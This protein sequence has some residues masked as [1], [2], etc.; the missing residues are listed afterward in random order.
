MAE[1]YQTIL[2]TVFIGVFIFACAGLYFSSCNSNV[3]LG[4]SV[5]TEAP[6][7]SIDYPPSNAVVR[8]AFVLAGECSDDRG[9]DKVEITIAN[10]SIVHTAKIE[11]DGTWKVDINNKGSD[12]SYP[13]ADGK[14]VFRAV[15]YDEV[16]RKSAIAERAIEIDN[17]EPVFIIKSPGG[18]DIKNPTS[19][20]SMFKV[21]GNIADDHDIKKF[22]VTIYDEA[23][24]KLRELY[25]ENISVAG[26]T[27]ITF[28]QYDR[29]VQYT[30]GGE[31]L[32]DRYCD[33]YGDNTSGDKPFYC[34]VR[35]VDAAEKYTTPKNGTGG[36]WNTSPDSGSEGN[37]TTK[38]YLYD[39]VY[40]KYMG[41]NSDYKLTANDF[42]AILNGSYKVADTDEASQDG[43]RAAGITSEDATKLRD[44][45]K[46]ILK[47][48]ATEKQRLTFKLN[49]DANPHY[50]FSGY[51]LDKSDN[52]YSF[53]NNSASK[54]SKITFTAKMGL[55]E[56]Y[57]DPKTI[58]VYCFGPYEGEVNADEMQT[59]YKDPKAYY[60]AK[61]EK[62]DTNKEHILFDGSEEYS[63]STTNSFTQTF[64]MGDISDGK[65]YVLAAC[66]KD[67]DDLEL[68]ESVEYGFEGVASGQPPRITITK[69]TSSNNAVI[70][71]DGDM[72]ITGT[73]TSA[74]SEITG[75]RYE[76]AVY[77]EGNGNNNL[78]TITGNV[79]FTKD[80]E[81]YNW[82]FDIKAAID[83]N[84]DYSKYKAKDGNN[85]KYMITVVAKN[86]LGLEGQADTTLAVD[87]KKP[88]INNITVTP[89]AK[90][91]TN[92]V[93]NGRIKVS[94][95]ISDS[96]LAGTKTRLILKQG[97]TVKK[98]FKD[99]YTDSRTLIEEYIYTTEFDDNKDLTFEVTVEDKAGNSAAKTTVCYIDQSTDYPKVS[100]TGAE[101]S[102]SVKNAGDIK[103]GKNLFGVSSR[104]L[105]G[106]VS[107]DDGIG[108]AYIS[109]YKGE[110][111]KEEMASKTPD[112]VNKKSIQSTLSY[113]LPEK[114]G[115]YTVVV[116]AADKRD[117]DD[118]TPQRSITK[119]YYVAVDSGAPTI[120]EVTPASG[121]YVSEKGMNVKGTVQDGSEIKNI[122]VITGIKQN[123]GTIKWDETNGTAGG[124]S[125]KFNKD[126]AKTATNYGKKYTIEDKITPPEDAQGT[127][128]VKYIATD[129]YGQSTEYQITYNID[130]GAPTFEITKVDN[131]SVLL[132]GGEATAPAPIFLNKSSGFLDVA[133]NVKDD[134]AFDGFVYYKLDTTVPN[135]N[136][137]KLSTDWGRS[138]ISTTD[139]KS[140]TWKLSIPV[141]SCTLVTEYFLYIT[142]KDN[143][144]NVSMPTANPSGKVSVIPDGDVPTIGNFNSSTKSISS[145]NSSS[146][147][148]FTVT[149]L[150]DGENGSGI[151]RVLLLEDGNQAVDAEFKLSDDKTEGTLTVNNS[152]YK[153]LY[154]E[155]R[156]HKIYAGVYDKV[157]NYAE[158][159]TVEI[160]VDSTAPMVN[161]TSILQPVVKN[162]VQYFNGVVTAN[163]IL[164][165]ETALSKN[166]CYWYV[167]Y[168]SGDKISEVGSDNI[169]S[170]IIAPNVKENKIEINDNEIHYKGIVLEIDTTKISGANDTS[171]G[172]YTL[173]V[174]AVDKGGNKAFAQKELKIDQSTDLP[175]L[176][177]N[178]VDDKV[179]AETI[180]S[181]KNLF[182]PGKT[183]NVSASDDDG[184]GAITYILYKGKDTTGTISQNNV[185]VSNSQISLPSEEGY[186]TLVVTVTDKNNNDP[187][188]P[189]ATTKTYHIAVDSGAPTFESVEPVSGKYYST[190]N[191]MTVK[192]TVKDENGIE[193]NESGIAQI[194]RENKK[195]GTAISTVFVPVDDNK[196]FTDTVTLASGDGDYEVVYTATD[197]FGQ[198]STH[199]I[200]YKVDSVAPEFIIKKINGKDVTLNVSSSIHPDTVYLNK[201]D[202]GLEVSGTVTDA[203]AGASGFDGFVYYALA[204]SAPNY[205]DLSDSS[206]WK[207]TGFETS[208]NKNGKWELS[209][210]VKA[211]NYVSGTDYFLYIAFKDDAGNISKA[212]ANDTKPNGMVKVIPD[213]KA[214]TITDL[215]IITD[216]LPDGLT[217]ENKDKNVVVTATVKDTE[218]G[219]ASVDLYCNGENT[220]LAPTKTNDEYKFTITPAYSKLYASGVHTL[221]VRATDKTR[222]E[223][224]ASDTISVDTESPVIAINSV[225]PRVSKD[226]KEY[227]NGVVTVSASLQDETEL[228]ADGCYWYVTKKGD[229]NKVTG[230]TNAESDGRIIIPIT[231]SSE[232]RY[233]NLSISLN[234]T[235]ISGEN[236]TDTTGKGEYTLH[237]YAV[238]KAGN[239][240]EVTAELNIDQSTDLPTLNINDVDDS[241]SADNITVDAGKNLFNKGK[242]LNGSASDDDGVKGITYSLYTGKEVTG[243]PATKTANSSTISY[244][245]PD[246]EGYYTL[247]VTVSDTN[248]GTGNPIPTRTITKTYHIAVDSGAPT[249]TGVTP[250]NGN[251]FSQANK[252]TV[253]GTVKDGNEIKNISV[254]TGKEVEKDG[255]IKVEWD[256][257][258]GTLGGTSETFNKTGAINTNTT[259][260]KTYTIADIITPPADDGNYVVKY[261]ATDVFG[262]SSEHEIKYMVDSAAPTFTIKKIGSDSVNLKGGSETHATKVFL[263]ESNGSL[264]VSGEVEDKVSGFDGFAYYALSASETAPDY[265]K[266]SDSNVWKKSAIATSDNKSGKWELSIPVK[267]YT[268][269]TSYYLHMTFKDGAGN[270][271]KPDENAKYIV[272]VIPDKDAPTIGALYDNNQYANPS[273]ITSANIHD[274]VYDDVVI[275]ATVMDVVSGVASVALYCDGEDTNL[276][277]TNSTGNE[278][279]LTIKKTG[280]N[281]YSKL[282]DSGVHNLELRATDK[283]GNIAS[284]T[285]TLSVDTTLP[286]VSINSISPRVSK[287]SDEYLNGTV[288]VSA[289]LTD[290]TA[291]VEEGDDKICYWYVTKENDTAKIPGITA[292]ADTEGKIKIPI[293]TSEKQYKNL[294]IL[295]DTTKI[296]GENATDT[297]GKGKYILHIYA[298]DKAGND[299]TETAELNID[300]STDIPEISL[301]KAN[302]DK[303]GIEGNT[304]QI[305]VKDDD[306]IGSVT[307]KLDEATTA[308][309]IYTRTDATK[310]TDY[311]YTITLPN[312]IST[313]EHTLTVEVEDF[314]EETGR[315]AK[316]NEKKLKFIYDND[317]PVI[318]IDSLLEFQQETLTIKVSASDKAGI[319]F[320]VGTLEKIKGSVTETVFGKD[321]PVTANFS[322]TD[323][324]WMATATIPNDAI[325]DSATYKWT[326]TVT[327]KYGRTSTAPVTHKVDV[328]LPVLVDS[329]TVDADKITF[330]A[331]T[332]TVY[333]N[334]ITADNNSI[335]FK[336]GQ[337]SI[338]ISGKLTETN[339]DH[340]IMTIEGKDASGNV[341]SESVEYATATP[342][343]SI[344][345]TYYDGTNQ[346]VLKA[347][348]KAGN[349]S[350]T[351][352]EFTLRVDTNA[353]SLLG[354]KTITDAN[355]K[356]ITSGGTVNTNQLK[357]SYKATDLVENSTS[358][359][360]SGLAQIL[361]GS[362]YGFAE[363][364]ALYNSKN[365]DGTSAFT[366]GTQTVEKTDQV[367]SLTS[368]SEG[369]N[370]LYIRLID[371]AGNVY[372]DELVKFTYD[373]TPATVSIASPAAGATVN[374]TITITGSVSD[375]IGLPDAPTGYLQIKIGSNDWTN[376]DA[377]SVSSEIFSGSSWSCKFDTTK[378]NATG[379]D[380]TVSVRMII[381]DKA[382]NENT[383]DEGRQIII[384]QDSDRPQIVLTNMDI[385]GTKIKQSTMVYG[386]LTDD[387]SDSTGVVQG[388][389][390]IEKSKFTAGKYPTTTADNGWTKLAV[391]AGSGSFSYEGNNEGLLEFYFYCIDNE[392]TSFYW[393]AADALG[394]MKIAGINNKVDGE[395]KYEDEKSGISYTADMNAPVVSLEVAR[396]DAPTD[397]SAGSKVFSKNGNYSDLYM[398]LTVVEAVEMKKDN[399]G[400]FATPIVKLN[401]N[402]I[403]DTL[404]RSKITIVDRIDD[405]RVNDIRK[406]IDVLPEAYKPTDG[407]T[408]IYEIGPINLSNVTYDKDTWSLS[409]EVSDASDQKGVGNMNITMDQTAPQILITSPSPSISDAVMAAITI[410]GLA[411]DDASSIKDLRWAIP[412]TASATDS[413]NKYNTDDDNLGLFTP[414]GASS[415]WEIKFSSGSQ[416][417]PDSLLFYATNST[418][419]KVEQTVSG[420]GI[421]KVPIWFYV[422]DAVG[423]K[424][425]QTTD[426]D[427]KPLE[428]YVDADGGK[429]K[430]W[431]NSPEQN[432]TVTGLVTIY[433]G[434]SD[435]ISVDKVQ[436]QVDVNGDGKYDVNDYTSIKD[437]GTLGTDIQHTVE[438]SADG[439]DWWIPTIG[440]N[441]WKVT[442]DTS[443]V[444]ST[445]KIKI[446]CRAYDSETPKPLTRGWN[447]GEALEVT[448]DSNAPAIRDVKLVQ[449]G[450]SVDPMDTPNASPVSELE[451]TSGMYISNVS[452]ATN[453]TWYLTAKVTDNEEV[454]KI[455]TASINV[456][457]STHI[458]DL[459][460]DVL[461]NCSTGDGKNKT[462]FIPITTTQSG[463]VYSRLTVKDNVDG[464]ALKE[465][466]INIDSTA[467]SLFG[468]DS[469]LTSNAANKLRLKP[470]NSNNPIGDRNVPNREQV[471]NSNGLFTFGDYVQEAESGLAFL[472]FYFE[473]S[474]TI[475]D[476]MNKG[477]T[478]TTTVQKN[479]ENLPALSLTV[480]R[481]SEDSLTISGVSD[482]DKTFIRKGGLVK[483]GGSYRLITKVDGNTI[484]FTP[485]CS[486]SFTTAEI[487]FAQIVD[488]QISESVKDGKVDPNYDD[489]DGMIESVNHIGSSYIWSASIDS[490][491]IADGPITIGVAA[492]DNAGNIATGSIATF[493]SNNRPR[494]AK[495]MLATDLNGDD[496]FTYAA[497]SNNY[498]PSHDVSGL[499]ET[500]RNSRL[501]YIKN[502]LLDGSSFGEFNYYKVMTD[503][504]IAQ[505]E[506]ELKS[507]AFKVVTKLCVLPEFVGGN[508]EI[509][510]IMTQSASKDDKYNSK[511]DGAESDLKSMKAKTA[512][513]EVA[514]HANNPTGDQ[515]NSII[516]EK[517][518]I[519]I[520]TLD[521]NLVNADDKTYLSFTFW[522]KTEGTNQGETSQWAH[523]QV[524]ITYLTNETNK[525]TPTINPFYWNSKTDNS[526]HKENGKLLGH[527]E[528]GAQPQVSGKIVIEGIAKDDVRLDS[529]T[530]N[531]SGIVSGA[532]LSYS[533]GNWTSSNIPTGM[534]FSGEDE[535]ISQNG[536][537][538]K[539]TLVCDTEVLSTKAGGSHITVDATDWRNNTHTSTT[540]MPSTTDT[541][542]T[543]HYEINVVPYITGVWTKLSE[544]YRSAPSVYARTALGH[545]PVSAGETVT[546]YGY[547]LGGTMTA[548]IGTQ[549]LSIVG[550]SSEDRPSMTGT[551]YEMT[552]PKEAKSGALVLTVG[553]IEASNNN[554]G[555]N[556]TGSYEGTDV[557]NMY[558]RQPNNVNNNTLTDD[559]FFDVWE[560]KTAAEPKNGK[561]AYVTMKINPKTGM[562][563]FS[564]ANSILYFNMPGYEANQTS[565]WWNAENGV[566]A[567]PYS[568][569][570]MG[571]NYGGFTHNTFAFDSNGDAYGAAIS[572]DTQSAYASAYFQFFSREQGQSANNTAGKSEG[573]NQNMNYHN[574]AN[575][576]RL[577][578]TSVQI[579]TGNEGWVTNI[580]RIQSPAMDTRVDGNLTYVYIAYYDDAAKQVRLRW[581]TVGDQ[582]HKIDG[583][584][585]GNAHNAS[586]SFNHNGLKNYGLTD[587]VKEEVTGVP[588]FATD[589]GEHRQSTVDDSYVKYS[590]DNNGG[591]PIQIVA[592]TGISGAKDEYKDSTTYKAGKYVSLSMV[593]KVAIVSWYDEKE[594]NLI[595]AYNTD[596]TTNTNWT[597]KQIDSEAGLNVKTA[598]DGSGGI[599]F[600]YYKSTGSDLKYAYLSSYNASTLEIVTVDSFGA[601]GA[602]CTIDVAKVGDNYVPYIS[603]QNNGYLGTQAAA[604]VAYRTDF[605]SSTYE[606]SD[607][608]DYLTGKW[609]ISV[610]PTDN[611]PNDDLIN[612]GLT[613]T[614]D[615]E[616]TNSVTGTD[617]KKSFT[618]V[619]SAV[620]DATKVWA[621]GT[622]NPLLGYGIDDGTI[623]MAQMK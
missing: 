615:G 265:E 592:A 184:I 152:T 320:V 550:K 226:D 507:E 339:P 391:Q 127:Y 610:V 445:N 459:I 309:S 521:E 387:D 43:S 151:D 158:T 157:G 585:D 573:M 225:L 203:G 303:L 306:E 506:A 523:L 8:D 291:L 588:M 567:G 441:S 440:T 19:Y 557:S 129:I 472:A 317:N 296:S 167:K 236:A 338:T 517:G 207:K 356:T 446:R 545:Y 495:V 602:K 138:A 490:S 369:E 347:V 618:N 451:Y 210:P 94:F 153:K 491:N 34:T 525:P 76:I 512:L 328:I 233:M 66:G 608:S 570:P 464:A 26:G 120:T 300:Q 482:N 582:P 133:G 149:G 583:R 83:A 240:I 392:G 414:I 581:G 134:V 542:K 293:S 310:K 502:N 40:T 515:Y 406:N 14:Y 388:L 228:S 340:V 220:N 344:N 297:T 397:Y 609:E 150:S 168:E 408:Y 572:T 290:E 24:K 346:V 115:V 65:K 546:I 141:N 503:T 323:N 395:Y 432:A 377:N 379:T 126:G 422:E 112:V 251:Y 270:T 447:A 58:T 540:E 321:S 232:K 246:V 101:D 55:D 568:Q 177:I 313:G 188:P 463:M 97:N 574:Q 170:G 519:V 105:N 352:R 67:Q 549:T 230:I 98:E 92:P 25:E 494:I 529:V 262:Q 564:Y 32:N 327:D 305:T 96:Y 302:E 508:G 103:T 41:K 45:L 329:A 439:D 124:T 181:G 125:E 454:A 510:Y 217:N 193:T 539:W 189:R 183:L 427:G 116:E 15:A 272:E 282:Y 398:E 216:G 361:I 349:E 136:Y 173:Y 279:N 513:T 556:A 250:A 559:V 401:G 239:S 475:Y 87:A 415:A 142:F 514:T 488:H 227:L 611:I 71:L 589:D 80:A 64:T 154:E 498:V 547:N 46:A 69:P 325:D 47:D 137:D 600:A 90:N 442:I 286:V 224:S 7:V 52:K 277:L 186:Y 114:E 111:K 261:T 91:D 3:G 511:K 418:L 332:R 465:I 452:V 201:K 354:E 287:D 123:D 219:V 289:I 566:G 543:A 577:D 351:P 119:T 371:V 144:N 444:T 476:P 423:N 458:V 336:E 135:Y 375:K 362:K 57:I 478:T 587:V 276:K 499:K 54:G 315:T 333:S 433:G 155:S 403:T 526:V 271:S 430:A 553:G 164:T 30:P 37:V 364:Q 471:S 209:I 530:V 335:W 612:V 20:G 468:T 599:H 429:P 594:R 121:G 505:E 169:I 132:S 407:K 492:I 89:I 212:N 95:S 213:G 605:T 381:P 396:G 258:N 622:Q 13:L 17:T 409:A 426:A 214:P 385:T 147:I 536:H 281:A 584:Q 18:I 590:G 179:S 222:N 185:T 595:M 166:E 130:K 450:K 182:N 591:I 278:Y 417:S 322:E 131:K 48:T 163:I 455:T 522:D 493:V 146:P 524:P 500:D 288:T 480:T 75:V 345:S 264:E 218:S 202:G 402:D 623:E 229:T 180:T 260:G 607:S 470:S 44:E 200:T 194:K 393:K 416:D 221:E 204:A 399:N 145:T 237:I 318:A 143:A 554:N 255:E 383:T 62:T 50:E 249:I 128:A 161:I 102:T 274:G 139:N 106:S 81:K 256:E 159:S 49:K 266:L 359:D 4:E 576:S 365:T 400:K 460:E 74:A 516:S 603:Y 562:P 28:A 598:V 616:L 247:V 304:I 162:N 569:L 597:Y 292:N 390:I 122:S 245:L 223:H 486:T 376:A 284:K 35:I 5:D 571:M 456:T 412:L 449:F 411:Q 117:A 386:S 579:K 419:Y 473:R 617:S 311:S 36:G 59:I 435:N 241:I 355:G 86:S 78:G 1:F 544:F 175:T 308:T 420:S 330:K 285:F 342:N 79:A 61:Y 504:G 248:G 413:N 357:L 51:A 84:K 187:I 477:V 85:Y 453:G 337:N 12:S 243:T 191:P 405:K 532:K 541:T 497:S 552:I 298:V 6:K 555:N 613:K 483:I 372:E 380:K 77:D 518:G 373:V 462:I 596:P 215:K 257:T 190:S 178:D 481:K 353:P 294:S 70:K 558:N 479:D 537:T 283:T 606:G 319:D 312:D 528:L 93:V 231:N 148:T 614:A 110:V 53:S 326:F 72:T 254:I 263:N 343:Y 301:N 485:T 259:Y 174:H 469:M 9:V 487:I 244:K 593:G 561:A 314:V 269:G 467:P 68:V 73:A 38:V 410:K 563:G 275:K 56:T 31:S 104:T 118:K 42:K 621:N 268:S 341:R 156:V 21:A 620:G 211:D 368:L 394:R 171:K 580:D 33:I 484:S 578:S 509:K 548:K 280:E 198:F 10:S 466:L 434:A 448:I 109:V 496:K 60:A 29:K 535:D 443:K 192:G 348:D 538:M 489:G 307:Y 208:D 382:G 316:K 176:T 63:G 619:V 331:G 299:H 425:V 428:I 334:E 358:T 367:I 461:T 421:Y 160:S 457:T 22:Y 551:G 324:K 108:N 82:N 197:V 350:A 520:D 601:V 27:E 205:G 99:K 560:F 88:E 431:I 252:M 238:D 474:D 16:G 575:A 39:D 374:K 527:I 389:Y 531:V 195:D 384:N 199:R 565:G 533:G 295:L 140:G 107:D 586:P 437:T 172:T 165:D 378:Y 242:T 267:G 436:I 404:D 23:N 100:I 604:K 253:K 196:K 113:M 363:A 2:K 360:V 234:T 11:E 438:K 366:S 501:T 273:G 235:Q 424:A 534:S 370:T 206:V